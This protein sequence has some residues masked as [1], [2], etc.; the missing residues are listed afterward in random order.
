MAVLETP[1]AGHDVDDRLRGKT[2][3]KCATDV[4]DGHQSH[5]DGHGYGEAGGL[6]AGRPR[7]VVVA[8][9]HWYWH[10]WI[11]AP[12]RDGCAR[13]W[14]AVWA[15]FRPIF[16]NVAIATSGTPDAGDRLRIRSRS[17]RGSLPDRALGKSPFSDDRNTRSR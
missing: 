13:T 2:G 5:S 7:R 3:H 16:T 15:V 17:Y 12:N 10:A 4:L 14:G 9:G 1:E 8:D 11:I 6:E